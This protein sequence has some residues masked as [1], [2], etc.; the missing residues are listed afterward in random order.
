MSK[1]WKDRFGKIIENGQILRNNFNN[2]SDQNVILVNNKF[3]FQ[4]TTNTDS[5]FEFNDL[6]FID[7]YWE[8]L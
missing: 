7:K 2:V 3:C 6:Y 8:I 4:S 5:I 1:I